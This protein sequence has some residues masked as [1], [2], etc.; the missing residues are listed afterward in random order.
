M[1]TRTPEEIQASNLYHS[2]TRG[3]RDGA[4]W[5]AMRREFELH[6]DATLVAAYQEGYEEGKKAAD[7]SHN[8]ASKKYK[9]QPD[10]LR[11]NNWPIR[12]IR[13]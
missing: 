2:Y 3:W 11:R 12:V 7:E 1:K 13:E 6:Q 8:A 4:G 5:R 10:I 9:Y